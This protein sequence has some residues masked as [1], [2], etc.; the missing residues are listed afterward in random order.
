MRGAQA[1]YIR[2]RQRVDRAAF[3]PTAV[4]VV[5]SL[6]AAGCSWINVSGIVRGGLSPDGERVLRRNNDKSFEIYDL[7]AGR[8]MWR[9]PLSS[10]YYTAEVWFSSDGSHLLLHEDRLDP[11]PDAYAVYETSTGVRKPCGSEFRKEY[12]RIDAMDVS[13]DGRFIAYSQSIHHAATEIYDM[14]TRKVVYSDPSHTYA[15]CF[16][17]PD[18]RRLATK[19][20]ERGTPFVQVL[21]A[22]QDGWKPVARFR[23]DSCQWIAGGLGLY[24][25]AGLSVWDG[26]A[27]QV[28]L[29]LTWQGKAVTLLEDGRWAAVHSASHLEI[30][31][32]PDPHAVF[33]KVSET[34]FS[35]RLPEDTRRISA[36]SSKRGFVDAG[37]MTI[38]A[39]R[40]ERL[41]W[42]EPRQHEVFLVEVDLRTARLLTYRSLG[43]NE[44]YQAFHVHY[45]NPFHPGYARDFSA[46]VGPHGKYVYKSDQNMIPYAFELLPE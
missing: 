37:F 5:A 43:T 24:T 7:R 28:I 31:Q 41:A 36:F 19:V 38:P 30:F 35:W 17:S 18:G 32:R 34:T 27:V 42:V 25:P 46:Y 23:A 15:G 20:H 33:S 9:A 2:H 45:V 14:D 12:S 40:G 11:E 44:S 4:L 39:V 16:F 26:G 1:M 10:S 29:P 8:A 3:D 21:A 13:N 22:T 6:W